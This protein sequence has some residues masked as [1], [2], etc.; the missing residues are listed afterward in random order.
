[1]G[2]KL[3]SILR[4]F[5]GFVFII[6]GFGKLTDISNFSQIVS[7]LNLLPAFLISPVS[8]LL[9]FVEI[10]LGAM[11]LLRINVKL[12]SLGLLFLSVFFFFVLIYG[13]YYL[14]LERC[15]CFGR[16]SYFDDKLGSLVKST[17]LIMLIF[18]YVLGEKLYDLK[19]ISKFLVLF[20]MISGVAILAFG[21]KGEVDYGNMDLSFL[22]NSGGSEYYL[23]VIFSP[24]DCPSCLYAMV[25][26]WN[27]IDSLYNEWLK[28][29]GI[30]YSGDSRLVG[31][32]VKLYFNRGDTLRDFGR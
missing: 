30:A 10:L 32:V 5:V 22:G 28:V 25:P 6:S 7:E 11:L 19:A 18:G 9:P 24:F 1:M 3:V 27:R 4:I 2:V 15:G 21:F 29:V 14:G 23:L 8:I 26:V 13:F 31:H 20:I 16:F 12:V 17:V